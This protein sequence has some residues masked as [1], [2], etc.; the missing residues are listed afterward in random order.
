MLSDEDR[1]ALLVKIDELNLAI[2]Q[3]KLLANDQ[4]SATPAG[5]LSKMLFGFDDG[6]TLF[7][8]IAKVGQ[9]AVTTFSKINQIISNSEQKQLQDFQRAND[10][11]KKALEQRLNSGKITQEQYNTA[12]SALDEEMAKKQRKIAHDQA[13]R[14]KAIAVMQAIV[15]TAAGVAAQLAIPGAG[16]GLAIAAAAMG[17]IEIAIAASTPVPALAKGNRQKILADDGKTYNAKVA[18]SDHASG[19][20]N[21]PTYVPGFGLFGE[22]RDPELVFNPRDTQ[23]IINSPALIDAINMTL[24]GRQYAQGNSREIIRENNTVTTTA[25]D[26]ETM[27]LLADIRK[28]LDQ[29]ATAYLV[30]DED[31]IRTHKKKVTEYDTF[32]KRVSN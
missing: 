5:E 27:A 7:E 29:P 23:S 11:K 15:N 32:K 24:G 25:M 4:E 26:P 21:E 13:V 9:F 10:Q 8:R 14:N 18:S 20:F 12:I 16:I 30:A 3:L 1:D 22:T 19:L 31:Y 28:K 17:A 6:D 2:S